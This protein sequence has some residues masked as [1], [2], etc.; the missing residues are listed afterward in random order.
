MF[1]IRSCI[2]NNKSSVRDKYLKG[3]VKTNIA[4]CME[5]VY[6]VPN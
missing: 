4:L 3:Q 5:S 6:I 1:K 2:A